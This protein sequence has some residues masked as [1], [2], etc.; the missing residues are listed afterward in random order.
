MTRLKY[1]LDPASCLGLYRYFNV[2]ILGLRGI[3]GMGAL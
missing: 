2:G 1:E 3:K